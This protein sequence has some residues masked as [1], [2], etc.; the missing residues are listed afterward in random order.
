MRPSENAQTCKRVDGWPPSLPNAR[1]GGNPRLAL[2][3]QGHTRRLT[4]RIVLGWFIVIPCLFTIDHFQVSTTLLLAFLFAQCPLVL[5]PLEH[6]LC[7]LDGNGNG[8]RVC[9]AIGIEGYTG[10]GTGVGGR[11]RRYILYLCD[12]ML[13]ETGCSSSVDCELT[14]VMVVQQTRR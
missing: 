4:R 6:L 10:G 9:R 2:G 14:C 5:L 7:H 1:F 13:D 8:N 11:S 3:G 12:G